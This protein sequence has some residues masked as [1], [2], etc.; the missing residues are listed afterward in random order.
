[1]RRLLTALVPFVVTLATVC[2]SGAAS[3]VAQP[4]RGAAHPQTAR[5][6]VLFSDW[7][8]F[9]RTD[10]RTGKAVDVPASP[11]HEVWSKDLGPVYAEPLMVNGTLI[12]AN[13]RDKVFGIDP[14]SGNRRWT[15][16]LGTP[17]PLSGL[18]CGNIDPLG[19]TGTPAYDADTGSVFVVAETKG[20]HHTLW[21]LS[22]ADGSKRWHRSMDVLQNRNRKAEQQRPAL[23]VADGRVLVAFG[24]L[25][26]DCGNYVGYVT[27]TRTDGTGPTR[28]FAVPTQREGGIWATPGPVLGRNGHVYVATGNGQQAGSAWDKSNAVLELDARTMKLVSAFAPTTWRADSDAD[29]DL[30]T[31]EP[32]M[33]PSLR[34]IVTGGKR[35]TFYLL[36]EHFKGVG[37]GI[38]Q[39][40]GC[41]PFGGS[42]STG[43]KVIWP[44]LFED[45]IRLMRVG[46]QTLRWGWTHDGIFGAP[47]IAGPRVYVTDRDSGDLVVLDLADGTQVQRIHAGP[48][49]HFPSQTLSGGMV[50]VPTLTGVTAFSG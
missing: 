35:G 19:I 49:T 33:V 37:R 28:H 22:A 26:G 12:V 29:L 20:G 3:P 40:D 7:P 30:A 1:M 34:R 16:D 14:L 25:A 10:A 23:L 15:V 48:A 18:P 27:S 46:A 9:H 24:G 45:K 8:T 32:V 13:E 39:L 6:G 2:G 17:Q 5:G 4:H 42:A 31:T 50:F 43:R 44:C 38:D 11:L 36:H 41:T 21:A 47:V